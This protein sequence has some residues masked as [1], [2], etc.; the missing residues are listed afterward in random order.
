MKKIVW[1]FV[2]V[3]AVL[4]S[5]CQR[6]RP[7]VADDPAHTVSVFGTTI[8]PVYTSK[9][10]FYDNLLDLYPHLKPALDHDAQPETITIPGLKQTRSLTVNGKLGTSKQMDPQGLAVTQKDVIISAYSRDKAYHSVLYL[11]NK[12][13]GAYVKQIVMPNLDHVGGIAYDPITKRLWITTMT[14]SGTA[15]LS[16]YDQKT[17]KYADF[18]RTKKATPFDHVVALPK[19]SRSSFLTYHNNAL[20]VG[21]F[22]GSGQGVF[23]SYPLNQKGIPQTNKNADVELRGDDLKVGSYNTNKRLQGVTFYQGKLLFSQ[24][25]GKQPSNLLVFDNDGQKKWLD[26]D[27]DDTLK[28]VK[29]PP[30][31][32]QIV[33]DGSDLYVLFESASTHY[34]KVDLDFHADRVMKLDL[35]T[36]LK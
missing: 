29:M 14:K 4:L 21:Y 34:R 9:K 2:V 13:T 30:Y 8:S 16:A 6:N 23:R 5:G 31:L 3:A 33:A 20:F 10:Q 19:I 25:F 15:S 36:L 27:S 11:L 26:F 12:K 32:E 17:L 28:T 18:S 24:S 1:G 7:Q 22:A 35:K